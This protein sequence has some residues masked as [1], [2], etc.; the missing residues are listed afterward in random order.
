M[1]ALR[2]LY[3]MQRLPENHLINRGAAKLSAPK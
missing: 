1:L 2:E 3:G